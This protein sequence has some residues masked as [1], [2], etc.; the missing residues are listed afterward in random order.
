[1]KDTRVK[2][3]ASRSGFEATLEQKPAEGDWMP[4]AF[5]LRY[6]DAQKKIYSTNELE[7]LAVV[8]AVELF[9][10]YLLGREFTIA[11]DHKALTSALG[12]TCLSKTYQSRLT[13]WVHRLLSYQFKIVHIPRKD[14][15]MFDYLSRE[16]NG[17]PFPEYELDEKFVE[18]SIEKLYKALYCWNSRL[19]STNEHNQKE[20]I[21]ERF[22]A[23][24]GCKNIMNRSSY[25]CHSKQIGSKRTGL[26][27]NKNI[28]T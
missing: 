2:C 23:N 15:G 24:T 25:G 5:A 27:R 11:T 13:R 14:M 28:Q 20:D 21:L 8:W 1:M 9:K 4:I 19:N 3:D 6:L 17:E 12:E 16:P 22:V 7:L 18:T 10:H 26:D